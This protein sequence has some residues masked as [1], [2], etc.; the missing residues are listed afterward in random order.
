MRT[1]PTV[2][3]GLA[4]LAAT[5][6][7]LVVATV[8]DTHLAIVD[9]VTTPLRT[10][11]GPGQR[12][13]GISDLVYAIVGGSIRA[14]S[15]GL[16]AAASTGI[17]PRLEGHVSGR[18]VNAVVNGLI[19][20]ELATD[21]PALGIR[22]AVRL[23]GRD[24]T[25]S[26]LRTAFP[27]ATGKV[28]VF[29]HGL[30]EDENAW[31]AHRDRI[32]T[33]YAEEL[34]KAGWTVLMLRANT[35][36]PVATNAGV[37]DQLMHRVNSHWPVPIERVALVGHSQGGLVMRTATAMSDATWVSQ[38]TDLIT[39]G[40]P[41]Q[42]SHVARA[43]TAGSAAL[44]HL[45]ETAA[46]GR[47]LERRSHGIRDLDKGL[48]HEV[49]V[50]E[51]IRVRLVS[52]SVSQQPSGWVATALGDLLVQPQSALGTR[53]GRR[54]LDAANSLH[55]GRTHHFNLLNDP[56]IHAAITDWLC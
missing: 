31:S 37:F 27:D 43:A 55:L 3:D 17:G 2:L 38:V 5:A 33:T 23:D 48:P 18:L 24:L 54:R 41:H 40:T 50:P 47:I 34:V 35:G 14:A 19:G 8:R 32:G 25:Y 53:P 6:D 51:H 44:R 20:D 26:E 10:A 49:A 9:R 13:P 1:T 46:L 21:R 45:P 22:M 7:D 12:P 56:R 29:L 15:L 30:C 28:A 36:L 16:G 42:G 4:L 39:L 52:A 11:G